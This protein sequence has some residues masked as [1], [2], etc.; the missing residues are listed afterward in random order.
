MQIHDQKN[1]LFLKL[2]FPFK[3]KKTLT[4]PLPSYDVTF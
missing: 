2:Q 1:A 3:K 4:E